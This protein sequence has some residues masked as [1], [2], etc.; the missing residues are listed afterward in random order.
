MELTQLSDPQ[1]VL[2]AITEFDELGRGAF[3][4]KYGFGEALSYFIRWDGKY[5]DSKAI[6]GAAVGHQFPAEGPL[7]NNDFSGGKSTVLQKMAELGFAVSDAPPATSSELIERIAGV[8]KYQRE[9][10]SAPHKTLL[11]LLAIRNLENNGTSRQQVNNLNNQLK[12]LLGAIGAIQEN[13]LEPIWRLQ[14]D[15]LAEIV[16]SEGHL[17]NKHQLSQVPQPALL[18]AQHT[19]WLLP[20]S[21]EMLLNGDA[22]RE[23][24]I[25]DS[26]INSIPTSRR[27][28]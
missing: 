20:T 13:S 27:Q 25:Q 10:Y 2:D 28:P 14:R 9:G 8:K 16:S 4:A 18:T 22:T 21:V 24:V 7:S 17:T 12:E 15:G 26:P 5:Y 6:A 23:Q 11:L 3:L 1:A 19:E